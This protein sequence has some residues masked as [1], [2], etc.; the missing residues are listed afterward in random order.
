MLKF[1]AAKHEYRWADQIVPSVTMIVSPLISHLAAV[2]PEQLERARQEGKAIHKMVELDCKGKLESVPEWLQ[3]HLE[4]W[5]RF[6]AESGFECWAT[7]E[8]LYHPLGYAGTPDLIGTIGDP[9]SRPVVIDI[10][11]TLYAGPAVG[12]QLAAYKELWNRFNKSVDFLRSEAKHT[13]VGKRYAL[14]LRAEGT[15]RLVPYEDDEDWTT[16]LALLTTYRW[17]RKWKQRLLKA[18]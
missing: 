18:A 9:D 16:F 15:Y 3:G 7:E 11:R 1:D 13:K 12:L 6:V 8:P 17:E 2:P 5:R 14:Q 4:A 10:K